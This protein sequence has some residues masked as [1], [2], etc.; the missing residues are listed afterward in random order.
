MQWGLHVGIINKW[1]IWF[2]LLFA[3]LQGCIL[4]WT[5]FT[6]EYIMNYIA[7]AFPVASERSGS[8]NFFCYVI[9]LCLFCSDFEIEPALLNDKCQTLSCSVLSSASL[10]PLEFIIL[11]KR[12]W[13]WVVCFWRIVYCSL[14]TS[15]FSNVCPAGENGLV[16]Y[17]CCFIKP[18]NGEEHPV[19]VSQCQYLLPA[20]STWGKEGI[21][22]SNFRILYVCTAIY[23][24]TLKQRTEI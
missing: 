13:R 1:W 7:A 17:C 10:F 6:A 16:F 8:V 12:T 11:H 19:R 3:Y 22:T 21:C 24:C 4:L 5:I 20:L 14:S 18:F 23:H 9:Y 2:S 15:F